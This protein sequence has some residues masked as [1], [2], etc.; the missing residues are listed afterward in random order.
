MLAPR[1]GLAGASA[2]GV[3]IG[4]PMRLGVRPGVTARRGE[5]SGD[6][7]GAGDAFSGDDSGEALRGDGVSAC[8]QR[9]TRKPRLPAHAFV[10]THPT[11]AP[12]GAVFSSFQTRSVAITAAADRYRS[13]ETMPV[14]LETVT[15]QLAGA[16]AR[17]AQ[18][19]SLMLVMHAACAAS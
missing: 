18:R 2:T 14:R 13:G 17:D 11:L 4:G 9:Q 6:A 1:G 8:A 19:A 3:R 15:K 10:A 7:A 5:T 16:A 12:G